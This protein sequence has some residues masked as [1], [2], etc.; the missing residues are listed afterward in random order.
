MAM[1]KGL[2]TRRAKRRMKS[3]IRVVRLWTACVVVGAFVTA[4]CRGILGIEKIDCEH[5][6][7]SSTSEVVCDKNGEPTDPKE[8]TGSCSAG[9]CDSVPHPSPY[10]DAGPQSGKILWLSAG[11][12]HACAV[13]DGKVYCW[14]D[15]SHGQLGVDTGDASVS[16]SPRPV[17]GLPKIPVA[18]VSAG[19]FHTC[20]V[21]DV[22]ID[23]QPY[24][25]GDVYCWGLAI[26][27]GA[28]FEGE[29]WHQTPPVK[30]QGLPSV[31]RV[32]AGGAHSCA[33]TDGNRAF[34]WGANYLG[35]CG[36]DPKTTCSTLVDAGVVD[37][38]ALLRV[39][40]GV[41]P[42]VPVNIPYAPGADFAPIEE[43]IAIK[44]DTCARTNSDLYCWGSNCASNA[45]S[46][47][48]EFGLDCAV[49]G[50]LGLAPN[51][52][53]GC[54]VAHPTQP[55]GI[56]PVY[57]FALSFGSIYAVAQTQNDQEVLGIGDNKNGQLASDAGGYRIDAAEIP[58]IGTPT[59][60]VSTYGSDGCAIVE[61]PDGGAGSKLECWGFNHCGE[62]GTVGCGGRIGVEEFHLENG[63]EADIDM[64][65]IVRGDDFGCAVR[66]SAPDQV[67][68]WG[69][70]KDYGD[71]RCGSCTPQLVTVRMDAM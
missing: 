44:H 14:G 32:I 63:A 54:Y 1:A 39:P 6:C 9:A 8:C 23:G 49:G 18:S 37:R 19:A 43:L 55:F 2:G 58:V 60:L 42:P 5:K 68:C 33:I 40:A 51:L 20:A 61:S 36:L 65:T 62:L 30:V 15:N 12:A 56:Y 71:S 57:Q 48:A 38:Q 10:S 52:G 7:A 17:D 70:T 13:R 34:C 47:I 64:N 67:V 24:K 26:P 59:G 69:N 66:A 29:L 22:P 4:G 46:D 41:V 25:Q 3:A 35:Q 16:V 53:N 45:S 27:S 21:L 11:H 50:Q 28:P 31:R